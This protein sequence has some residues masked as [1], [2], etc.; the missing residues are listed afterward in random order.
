RRTRRTAQ[1]PPPARVEAGELKATISG[2]YKHDNLALFLFHGE[3]RI[4]GGRLLTLKEALE[5]KKIIIYETNEVTE[6]IVE[7]VGEE[8]VFCQAGERLS[9]D[10]HELKLIARDDCVIKAGSGK[11]RSTNFCLSGRWSA[12]RAVSDI[13]IL[14]DGS[15]ARLA[16]RAPLWE[17]RRDATQELAA[18]TERAARE[19]A[20]A[21]D[22]EETGHKVPEQVDQPQPQA[23]LELSVEDEKL[24]ETEA[25]YEKALA[26]IVSERRDAIGVAVAINGKI[27]SVDVYGCHGIFAKLWPGLLRNAARAAAA[28]K[29]DTD[30]AHPSAEEVRAF[31]EGLEVARASRS[32]V[33][34]DAS[35][36]VWELRRSDYRHAVGDPGRPAK[37]VELHRSYSAI[38]ERPEQQPAAAWESLLVP[39]DIGPILDLDLGPFECPEDSPEP[40]EL[41]PGVITV[42]IVPM[43]PEPKLLPS[44]IPPESLKLG[45]PEELDEPPEP[46]AESEE[47]GETEELLSATQPS[48]QPAE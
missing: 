23:R 41:P 2:P 3:N 45:I 9:S 35:T 5:H 24:S 14:T 4:E 13:I 18:A 29:D 6:F 7:N 20:I 38:G 10:K 40:A 46:E 47:S 25:A 31:V 17:V 19:M 42:P 37:P 16:I 44:W 34:E 28:D 12:G 8:D 22:R 32:E 36:F 26:D 43:E 21:E 15:H 11:Q 30:F 33:E 48:E 39:P 27:R 1:A